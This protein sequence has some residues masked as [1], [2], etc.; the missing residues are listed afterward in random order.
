MRFQATSLLIVAIMATVYGQLTIGPYT[1]RLGFA[2]LPNRNRPTYPNAITPAMINVQNRIRSLSCSVTNGYQ[3]CH[4]LGANNQQNCEAA[5]CCWRRMYGVFRSVTSCYRPQ[6]NNDVTQQLMT[7]YRFNLPGYHSYASRFQVVRAYVDCTLTKP[8]GTYIRGIQDFHV[9]TPL[10]QTAA[11]VAHCAMLQW[12]SWSHCKQSCTMTSQ[13][14]FRKCSCTQQNS[15]K[16]SLT[17]TRSCV[18]PSCCG[19]LQWSSWTKCSVTCGKGTRTRYRSDNCHQ[20]LDYQTEVCEVVVVGS[21][22]YQH[23][24]HQQARFLRQ[25]S[26]KTADHQEYQQEQQRKQ[27]EHQEKTQ[28]DQLKLQRSVQHHQEHEE[29]LDPNKECPEEGC[30]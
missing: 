17:E 5:G 25:R 19:K 4:H 2:I 29:K 20:P 24:M 13:S 30:H 3:V 27:Q 21:Q 23:A 28:L 12:S 18:M 22:Q 9:P 6:S 10:T 8:R 26:L 15:C 16:G 1:V 11:P 14:R 7:L